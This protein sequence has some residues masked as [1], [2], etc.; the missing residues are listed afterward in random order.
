MK[1]NDI[2]KIREKTD[3]NDEK[4]I[5]DLYL[6]GASRNQIA[7]VLR[8]NKN[9]IQVYINWLNEDSDYKED[10][11][12]AIKNNRIA[13]KNKPKVESDYDKFLELYKEGANEDYIRS[14]LRVGMRKIQEYKESLGED[15]IEKHY[16]NID[17]FTSNNIKLERKEIL[18]KYNVKTISSFFGH[19]ASNV[20]GIYC[21][22]DFTRPFIFKKYH[23]GQKEHETNIITKKIVSKG[24]MW[25]LLFIKEQY[26]DQ[27]DQVLNPPYCKDFDTNTIYTIEE[28]ARKK[29]VRL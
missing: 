6:K 8:K 1:Y 13:S 9:D 4:T 5:I 16:E 10:R 26:K 24:D 23:S 12:L 11:N 2:N 15:D 3:E 14:K 27:I 22:I 19:D 7:T 21:R 20:K 18:A 28:L 25:D 29:N 17:N